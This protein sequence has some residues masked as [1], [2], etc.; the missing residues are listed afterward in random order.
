MTVKEFGSYLITYTSETEGMVIIP[1]SEYK[2]L[3]K[4]EQR[5]KEE[6]E[7]KRRSYLKGID[8]IV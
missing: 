1:L 2:R 5:A 8:K 4:V 6:F 7:E 3:L